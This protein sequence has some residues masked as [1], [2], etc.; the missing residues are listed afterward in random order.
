MANL[1]GLDGQK[2]KILREDKGKLEDELKEKRR[3]VGLDDMRPLRQQGIYDQFQ[4]LR[5]E[6]SHIKEIMAKGRE[7]HR[8]KLEEERKAKRKTADEQLRIH[9]VELERRERAGYDARRIVFRD[10]GMEEYERRI[11][12]TGGLALLK[13]IPLPSEAGGIALDPGRF[14]KWPKW[15]VLAVGPQADAGVA[16]GMTVVAEAYRGV[17]VVS[18]DDVYLVVDADEILCA[19]EEE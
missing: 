3:E 14:E 13:R 6:G 19:L 1:V 9:L 10:G 16:P 2:D 12:M 8:R 11:R 5:D 4:D 7:D 18:R 15:R 17:E